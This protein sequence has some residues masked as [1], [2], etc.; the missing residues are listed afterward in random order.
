VDTTWYLYVI[1]CVDG[2]LYAGITTD[3]RRRYR[4]HAGGGP[5][6][7]RYLRAHPPQE[8]VFWRRIATRSLA[9]KAEYNFKQLSKRAKEAVVRAGRIRIER[10]TGNQPSPAWRRLGHRAGSRRASG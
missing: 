8:L 5:R 6:A 4:E 10:K 2:S 1:R 3:V 7:A 9:L